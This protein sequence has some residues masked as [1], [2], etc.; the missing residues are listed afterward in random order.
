MDLWS[1]VQVG[2]RSRCENTPPVKL[3]DLE[4]NIR[5]YLHNLGIGE[6]FLS[7]KKALSIK[8]KINLCILQLSTSFY[9]MTPQR[10]KRETT[11][12]IARV[13]KELL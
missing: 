1:L 6:F 9:Q 11:G 12:P 10:V 5:E 3:L 2:E 13:H 4:D 8:E 7:H